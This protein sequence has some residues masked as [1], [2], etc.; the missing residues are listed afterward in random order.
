MAIAIMESAQTNTVMNAL[1]VEMNIVFKYI[2]KPACRTL[3]DELVTVC[4][5]PAT[6]SCLMLSSV[7]GRATVLR[8]MLDISTRSVEV[9]RDWVSYMEEDEASKELNGLS[10][11]FTKASAELEEA[12]AIVPPV[13]A[14]MLLME[15]WSADDDDVDI[16]P[17]AHAKLRA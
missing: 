16:K 7:A 12:L 17:I 8:V 4:T 3:D 10:L 6:E 2:G 9:N 11:R 5:S 13:R 1:A 15:F 14:R